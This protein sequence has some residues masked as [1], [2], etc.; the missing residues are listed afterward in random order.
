VQLILRVLGVL[1]LAFLSLQLGFPE[2]GDGDTGSSTNLRNNLIQ[3]IL[4]GNPTGL[5]ASAG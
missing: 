2:G 4:V 5:I 1:I 3:K